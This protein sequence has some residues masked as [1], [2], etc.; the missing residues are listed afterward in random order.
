MI[1]SLLGII[2]GQYSMIFFMASSIILLIYFHQY[3]FAPDKNVTN[4]RIFG[5]LI[6]IDIISIILVF[7][8]FYMVIKSTENYLTTIFFNRNTLG[9][10]LLWGYWSNTIIKNKYVDNKIIKMISILLFIAIFFTGSRSAILA[11]IIFWVFQNPIKRVTIASIICIIIFLL[12]GNALKDYYRFE[13]GVTHRDL[14]WKAGIESWKKSPIMGSGYNSHKNLMRQNHIIRTFADGYLQ[15]LSPHNTY[16]RYL[17]DFGIIGLVLYLSVWGLIIIKLIQS[18]NN[19]AR[20]NLGYI[21]GTMTHQFFETEFLFGLSFN[22]IM[23]LIFI[24]ISLSINKLLP[25]NY[26]CRK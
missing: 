25:A 17:V 16:I 22:N 9:M 14:L 21:M 19:L 8:S 4:N 12:F 3:F 26:V 6:I 7:I 18:K 10:I 5:I 1:I 23:L 13:K 15:N 2:R 11:L 24:Y 20:I